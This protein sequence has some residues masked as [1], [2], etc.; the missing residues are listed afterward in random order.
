MGTGF[1]SREEE[2][3]AFLD[4][5]LV[6]VLA[7]QGR[8]G[9]HASLVAFAAEQ[10]LRALVFATPRAT[11]KYT[12]LEHDPRVAL[13]VDDRSNQRSD[14]QAATA[15]TVYGRAGSLPKEG[16]REWLD[17]Y[18]AKHPGLSEFASSPGCVLVRI[19][20]DRLSVVNSFQQVTDI[21]PPS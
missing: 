14:F 2:V 20:V 11:R 3:Q 6:G 13:L 12:N 7:T 19:S 15:V 1:A 5:R 17:L 18:L 8:E 21:V 16:G 9:P 10:G 4:A